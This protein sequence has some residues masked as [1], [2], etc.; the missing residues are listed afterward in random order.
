MK[1]FRYYFSNYLFPINTPYGF[2]NASFEF[3]NNIRLEFKINR[4]Y[5][6]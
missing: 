6:L 1:Y 3:C 5:F 2:N 4:F